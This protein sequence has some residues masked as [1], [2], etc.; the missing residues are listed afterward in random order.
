[1]HSKNW[2]NFNDI[3]VPI[4]NLHLIEWQPLNFTEDFKLQHKY[5]LKLRR[6]KYVAVASK[7]KVYTKDIFLRMFTDSQWKI[8]RV[9]QRW[10]YF[11]YEI[12]SFDYL[13]LQYVLNTK[14]IFY[15]YH[16][17]NSPQI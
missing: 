9:I 8:F 13:L 17:N 14:F 11:D 10:G 6:Q 2:Q 16:I 12:S 7:E 3:Y 1:M 5:R 4:S 15:Y